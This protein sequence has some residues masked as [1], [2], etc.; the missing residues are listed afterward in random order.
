M[1]VWSGQPQAG[2]EPSAAK[3]TIPSL[4]ARK[5]V[6]SK[7]AAVTAYDFPS[8]RLADT[9]GIDLVLVGDS[10][11]MT[12]LGHNDTLAVTMDEMLVFTRAVRRGLKRALLVADMP[13]GSYQ[14]TPRDGV[15]NALRFVKEAGAEAVKLEGG[16]E[17]ADLVRRLVEAEIPVLGHLGLTPQAINRMGGYKVQAKTPAAIERIREDAHLLAG[18]GCFAIVLEGIPREVAATLTAELPVPTIGIGAGPDCDGQVL[19]WHD[20]LGL[21]VRENPAPKFV[22]T[23]LDGAAL[24]RDALVSYRDDVRAGTFPSEAESYHLAREAVTVGGR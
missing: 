1:S 8:A 13:F 16:R 5:P 4:L 9:A 22:R 10:L 17:R 20:L 23:Y 11:A 19:V 12:I 6:G 18:A 24:V 7:I 14:A 15:R 21:S 3:V 2:A